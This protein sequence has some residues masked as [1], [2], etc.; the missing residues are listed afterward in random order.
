L[1]LLLP[2]ALLVV[3]E[4][5]GGTDTPSLSAT[6]LVPGIALFG[7][8][9]LMFSSAMVLSRDRETALLARL[10]TAPLRS[11]DFVIAY[12]LPY[13][14][15]A[16]VQSIVVFAIG[17]LL[18]LEMAGSAILVVLIMLL[19][20]VFYIALGIVFGSLLG[21]AA[22]SGAYSA[23]LLLTI[24]GGAWFDLGEI[25]GPVKTFADYLPFAHA[26]D[27]SRAV[28]S[29][30]AGFGDVDTDL[31][32]VTGCTVLVVVLAIVSFRR[33]MQE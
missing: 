21:V 4:S 29:D 19:M 27:A 12:S 14:G 2:P 5:F 18:G 22:V 8:V 30:G 13:L 25:S 32:W 24:F 9:M 26:L 11:S 15:I 1:T 3:L 16:V 33:R 6:F 10:L 28:M 23:I 20:A 7:F 31:Y 17:A